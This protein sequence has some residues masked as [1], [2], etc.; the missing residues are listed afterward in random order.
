MS[1]KVN[2]ETMLESGATQAE[3]QEFIDTENPKYKQIFEDIRKNPELNMGPKVYFPNR[4]DI[5]MLL[6]DK[7]TLPTRPDQL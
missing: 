6:I 4:F 7:S 1:D 3:L 2:A 5:Y